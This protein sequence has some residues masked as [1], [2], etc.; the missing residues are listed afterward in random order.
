MGTSLD[1]W[2]RAELPVPPMPRGVEWM[3]VVGPGVIVLGVAALHAYNVEGLH[4]YIAALFVKQWDTQ[5]APGFTDRAFRRIRTDSDDTHFGRLQAQLRV[6]G[7]G[8][9]K[10]RIT[11]TPPGSIPAAPCRSRQPGSWCWWCR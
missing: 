4:G 1:P 5:Y 11:L 6:A 7:A 2:V 3:R 10:G 8:A 9:Q